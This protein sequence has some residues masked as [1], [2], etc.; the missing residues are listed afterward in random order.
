MNSLF[1]LDDDIEQ[2]GCASTVPVLLPLALDTTYDYL[3]SEGE[4]PEPGDFVLVPI[5]PR[6]EI[7]V[8]WE[9]DPQ[10]KAVNPKKLKSIIERFDLR[11]LSTITA[12]D[13][14]DEI[15]LL[16]HLWDGHG[17]TVRTVLPRD[18]AHIATLT[19]LIPGA[20]FY[21]REAGEMVGVTFDG[22]PGAGTLLLPD[23]GDSGPPLR[24]Q[25]EEVQ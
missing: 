15:V 14:G 13:T 25:P 22:H 6:K 4:V 20:A 2:D 3:P 1:S 17:L 19:D 21:E 7:G 10:A 5:G 11:H 12:E 8:V 18:G 23:D 24:R 9:R 16:Y